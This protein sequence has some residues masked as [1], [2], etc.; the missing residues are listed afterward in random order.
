VEAIKDLFGD[1]TTLGFSTAILVG[2]GVILYVIN[3]QLSA[4]Y[5]DRPNQQHYRQLIMVGV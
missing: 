3:R 4:L 5:K 1:L 2:L